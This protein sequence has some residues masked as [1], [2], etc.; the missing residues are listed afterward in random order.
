MLVTELVSRLEA[1][2]QLVEE[3]DALV[4][5]LRETSRSQQV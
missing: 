5:E 1:K 2:E 4:E 3:L